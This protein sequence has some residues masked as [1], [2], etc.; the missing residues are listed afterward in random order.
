MEVTMIENYEISEKDIEAALSYLKYH[1]PENAN[2]ENAI[3]LL[4][5]LKSGFHNMAHD[6]PDLLLKLQEEI[7]RNKES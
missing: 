2:R 6:N 1:D 7:D 5:D 3:A 4:E